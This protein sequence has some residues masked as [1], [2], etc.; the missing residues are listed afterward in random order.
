MMR[1]KRRF[2]GIWMPPDLTHAINFTG[3]APPAT[4][5]AGTDTAIKYQAMGPF[6]TGLGQGETFATTIGL[7]GDF[8]D[9]TLPNAGPGQT[10]ADIAVGY[11]LRRVVG[12]IFVTCDQVATNDADNSYAFAVTCGIIVRRISDSGGAVTAL[13]GPQFYENWR[14]P[15]LWRRTWVIEN[16][17]QAVL[18]AYY[19]PWPAHNAVGGSVHDGPHVDAKTRRTVKSEERLFLDIQAT[20]LNGTAGAGGGVN[21][22]VHVYWDLRFFGRTFQSSGNRNNA[23]R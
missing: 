21:S 14:D 5:T 20:T 4:I 9:S 10:L 17:P 6:S 2:R 18:S 7:I 23:S 8:N 16:Q 1:R 15:Y 3:Q 11:S 22:F 13:A 19:D 12:K